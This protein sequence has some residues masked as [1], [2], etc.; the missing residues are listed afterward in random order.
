MKMPPVISLLG[1]AIELWSSRHAFQH[2]GALA[3][4]TLFSMAPL[5]IILVSVVSFIFGEEAARGEIAGGIRGL[6]GDQA[7]LAVEGAV[8]RSRVEEAGILPTLIGVAMLLF[9]ATTVF[10]QVQNSLNQFWG[11]IAKPSRS[12]IVVFLTTRLLSLGMVL[13]IGFLM[14][15]SFVLSMVTAAAIEYAEDWFAVH[16]VMVA[17]IDAGVSLLLA[18]VIFGMMFKVLPD[19]YLRWADVWRAAALTAVLFILGQYLISVY[20][21]RF[22]PASIYGAAGSLVIILF[23]VYYSAL[24][25]FF[26]AAVSKC[27][28]LR[29]DGV[30]TPKR[31]AVRTKMVVLEEDER[32]RWQKTEEVD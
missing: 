20:L 4:Y 31:T 16:P 5:V 21:T 30:V 9:G 15:T 28:I 29:R 3:F 18:T 2:A 25:L 27:A 14:M 13:I 6:V 32:H 22:A 26:G 1:D 23:W 12:G 8:R 7:A 24:I 19:V 10:A 17:V 11:V